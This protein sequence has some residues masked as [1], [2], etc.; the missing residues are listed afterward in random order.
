MT[1]HI[2]WEDGVLRVLDQR[3]LPGEET[4]RD[5]RSWRDAETAIKSMIVRGAPLIGVAGAF[6]CV[7]AAGDYIDAPDWREKIEEATTEL[8]KARPTAVNLVWAIDLFRPDIESSRSARELREKWLGKA[9]DLLREDE[10]ICR[11]IGSAGNE[12][13]P[14]KAA[15]LTHCN[16][17]ALATAG[18][19][20]ALGVVR[21]AREAGKNVRVIADETRPFLQGSR[22]TAWELQKDGIPVKIACDNAAAWLMSQGLVDLAI[23]GADRVAAN[24]D[25]ANKIGTLG[26]A[27]IAKNYNIPFYVAAPISTIDANL[28]TGDDIPIERRSP[29]EVLRMAGAKIAPDEVSAFNYAF[30]VTP[31]NLISGLITEKGVLRPPYSESIARALKDARR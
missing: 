8:S 4:W 13:V 5:C 19:G 30:D 14:D 6:G 18:Y 21:A 2:Y 12:V 28:P 3:L 29:D 27:I 20:T 23:T 17:G 7:L 1:P 9:L 16:A 11:A 22:L 15:V 26:L 25:T 10:K 31:A 24:G